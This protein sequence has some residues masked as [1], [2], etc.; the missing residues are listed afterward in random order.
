MQFVQEHIWLILAAVASGAM[1]VW[2]LVGR[3]L[4]GVNEIGTLE[5][6]QLINRKNALILDVREEGEYAAGH[7]PNS[8]H[9]PLGQ[10]KER[11][12]E[13]EK[14]K[15]RPIV[16]LCRSGQRSISACAALKKQG[17]ADVYTLKGGLVAWEQANLPVE[18]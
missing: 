15:G 18:K 8:R 11:L 3:L 6:I 2:P 17:F 13:L 16:V 5:A 14:S 12:K 1:L 9:I 7:I 10:L 4:G